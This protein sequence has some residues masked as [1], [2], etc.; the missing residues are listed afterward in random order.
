MTST[1]QVLYVL[2]LFC[3]TPA[4]VGLTLAASSERAWPTLR[5]I[6]FWGKKLVSL[7]GFH[8]PLQVSPRQKTA[9]WAT[10]L[11]C[12]N[13]LLISYAFMGFTSGFILYVLM[14]CSSLLTDLLMALFYLDYKDA[15]SNW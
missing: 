1:N 8:E 4:V 14:P 11:G 10:V 6:A 12:L 7:I 5:S 3:T 13:A 9:L 2:L 15:S